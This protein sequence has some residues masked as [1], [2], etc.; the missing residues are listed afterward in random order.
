MDELV[1][2][3]VSFFVSLLWA[4]GIMVAWIIF[5]FMFLNFVS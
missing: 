1:H 2:I 3:L 5:L 4:I